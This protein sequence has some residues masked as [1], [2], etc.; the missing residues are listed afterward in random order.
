MPLTMFGIKNCDTI[1]QARRWLDAR[2][3]PYAFHDYKSVGIDRA[4]LERWCRT[5]GW[6]SICNRSGQTFRKL[7]PSRKEGLNEQ[8]AIELMVDQPS[9]IKRPIVEAG[10]R[11]IV[12]FDIDAYS[13]LE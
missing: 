4:R 10:D 6:E 3:I 13:T 11:T 12:G 1:K 5:H 9:M 2:S 8:R 7:P